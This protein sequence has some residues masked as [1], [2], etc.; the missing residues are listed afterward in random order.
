MAG[1][2]IAYDVAVK[3][4]MAAQ[5]PRGATPRPVMA[6]AACFAVA[7][8][9]ACS[10]KPEDTAAAVDSA[11]TAA[12]TAAPTAVAKKEVLFDPR[13]PPPGWVKCHRNHCHHQDGHVASY[14][15]VMQE[16]GATGIVGQPPPKAAPPAPPDVGMI[17]MDAEKSAS[18]LVTRV[19]SAGAGKEK[20]SATSVVSVHYTGWTT[21]G[22][23]FDSS[24]ARNQ[25]ARF[26][27]DKVFAGWTEGIQLMVVGEERRFWIPQELAFNGARGKPTGTLVFDV[28][29]LAI[30]VP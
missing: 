17:P 12:A 1:P 15:Q 27:L 16:M 13:N 21:D 20:P 23:A 18:G 11:S 6:F 14:A 24:V 29:L 26:P 5:Q 10:A 8:L 3:M 22:K 30:A 19:I 7:M 25:P 28:E 4:P 9:S 2:D